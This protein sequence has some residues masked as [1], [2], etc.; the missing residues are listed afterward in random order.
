M[1]RELT[2]HACSG[3][4]AEVSMRLTVL[5]VLA[6]I[7]AFSTPAQAQEV[8]LELVLLADASGSI[9]DAEIRFQRTGYAD[10]ITHPDVLSAITGGLTQKIAVTYV[11][12]GDET[13]QEVVVPWTIISDVVSAQ[14]FADRL[15]T[16]PRLAHGFNAIGSAL[17]AAQALI[18]GNAIQGLR[19]V[20]DISA[21]SAN[22]WGGVPIELARANAV[23]AGITINGL[24]ILCRDDDCGGRPVT[25]SVEEAFEQQII[26]GPRS[27]VV[28]V[29]GSK[30]FAEAVRQK[31]VLEIA[32]WVGPPGR[33]ANS[34]SFPTFRPSALARI[35]RAIRSR[36]SLGVIGFSR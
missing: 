8:D 15:L 35:R 11:E 5:T 25:Y 33:A 12:W 31:L 19:K 10:A 13:S 4:S 29:D 1:Q 20:I 21:D 30:S 7:L 28:T 26:G 6:V 23:A 17:A 32:A 18:E 3:S 16:T 24:A 14:A 2:Y 36:M 9:D 22:N 34:H 27:F